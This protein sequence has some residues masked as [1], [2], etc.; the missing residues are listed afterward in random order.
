M[1]ESTENSEGV[2]SSGGITSYMKDG[3]HWDL[4]VTAFFA[5]KGVPL[6]P[7]TA[8]RVR[9]GVGRL[10]DGGAD[11]AVA[12]LQ[13]IKNKQNFNSTQS[14]ETVRMLA[15][16]GRK[17]LGN[18]LQLAEQV[19]RSFFNEHNLKL[20]NRTKVAEAA[21]ENLARNPPSED[22][23][24]DEI[25]I[26]W[27]NHFAEIAGQKSKP[28]MQELLGKILAGEIRKPGA[29]SPISINALANL[30][31][32]VAKKFEALCWVSVYVDGGNFVLTDVFPEFTIKGIPEIDFSYGDMLLLRQYQLLAIDNGTV[33]PIPEGMS[34][35]FSIGDAAY[36]LTAKPGPYLPANIADRQMHSLGAAPFG[37]IGDE[38]RGLLAP[39]VP[40]W[41]NERI[42]SKL[43]DPLWTI[44]KMA[45]ATIHPGFFVSS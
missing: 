44:Q 4:A 3:K 17:E 12:W 1:S 7:Q 39:K 22:S 11:I 41:V 40:A 29:Y 35:I 24:S 5:A 28:E 21:L 32:Y 37:V 34:K 10:I 42:S 23:S 20:D 36:H 13:R 2:V 6:P 45:R 18:D 27:L 38:L 14:T 43:T 19:A 25:D 9:V 30:T 33:L 26:D 31:P 8:R 16:A 15:E